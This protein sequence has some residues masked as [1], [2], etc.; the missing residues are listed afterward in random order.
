MKSTLLQ[1]SAI[2]LLTAFLFAGCASTINLK[3]SWS[4]DA[5]QSKL[6]EGKNLILVKVSD[7]N[8]RYVLEE[9]FKVKLAEKG[10]QSETASIKFPPL[11]PNKKTTEDQVS[12]TAQMFKSENI[13]LV[14]L[15]TLKEID[16][17]VHTQ[18]SGGYYAGGGYYAPPYRRFSRYYYSYYDPGVYVPMS[19]T[20]SVSKNYHLETV[21][22]DLNG[23]E[24]E[25]LLSVTSVEVKDPG[26]IEKVAAK[27][28]QSVVDRILNSE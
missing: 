23:N 15:T 8:A 27:Y 2:L 9:Q 19:S 20:T 13:D 18:T 16:Q 1:C 28:A 3:G 24:N 6:D 25:Q 10:I 4:E 7:R 17:T 11:D 14:V 26:N 12:E 21:V 5:L 22:F